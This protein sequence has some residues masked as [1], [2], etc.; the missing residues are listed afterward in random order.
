M[1]KNSSL[2]TSANIQEKLAHLPKHSGV[3]HFLGVNAQVLYVGKA[4]NLR[5]RVKSYFRSQGLS[6][7]IAMMVEQ[8][9]DLEWVITANEQEAL[10]LE[11]SHIKNLKPKFNILFRDDKSYPYLRFSADKFPR[12]SYFRSRQ[13]QKNA[14]IAKGKSLGPYPDSGAVRETI[15]MLQKVFHLRTCGDS[16]FK[17]RKRPCL[18][19]Q[20]KRCSAPCVQLITAD[21][22]EQTVEMAIKFVEGKQPEVFAEIENKMLTASANLQFEKAGQYRDQLQ[23]LRVTASGQRIIGNDDDNCDLIV[24]IINHD[25]YALSARAIRGGSPSIEYH[26]A[27]QNPYGAKIEEIIF[28]YLKQHYIGN[29]KNLELPQKIWLNCEPNNIQKISVLHDYQN[30]INNLPLSKPT[31]TR[32][33]EW[34]ERLTSQCEIV[35][36]T[37]KNSS[38]TANKALED[39]QELLDLN[40]TP[41]RIECVDISHFSGSCTTASWVVFENGK[42]ASNHYRRYNIRSANASDDYGAMRELI[43][44]RYQ[45]LQTFENEPNSE[46]AKE[47]NETINEKA[48]VTIPDLLIIDGGK[49]QV[50]IAL[51][52][53]SQIDN[54]QLNE[55]KIIGLA[56][57]VE[58]IEG[59]EQIIIPNINK[60]DFDIKL[61]NLNN[62][63]FKLLLAVRDEAHRFAITGQR[64]LRKKQNYSRLEDISGVGAIL[65][66]RLI[67]RFG[68]A[69]AV[70]S[71][72]R[73]QLMQV[74]G[75]SAG[76][77]ERILTEFSTSS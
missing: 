16:V 66:K 42:P 3:Y 5:S 40:E 23:A 58:R 74:E 62:S 43:T 33:K 57:G 45:S 14:I 38:A 11:N 34:L 53:I 6:K 27:H 61:S 69:Q 65:R 17:N 21:D 47:K 51:E 8:I 32:E 67:V 71:A 24:A 30:E 55:M 13:N 10:V 54:P 49:G 2:A 7:R 37:T 64:A 41:N 19:Y 48:E 4:N 15:T 29:G 26:I 60:N 72:T 9:V 44:R 68:S 73:E 28:E 56:K 59:N 39:V 50:N 76:L 18:L 46:T 20:I 75:I 63:G 77:A 31:R 22:Y 52:V 35:L 36:Q 70:K 25:W 1:P 12:V